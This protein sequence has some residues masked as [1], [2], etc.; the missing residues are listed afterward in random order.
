MN[1]EHSALSRI[2]GHPLQ[3]TEMQ[4][5]GLSSASAHKEKYYIT[6]EWE[7]CNYMDIRILY[8]TNIN[9]RGN[10][11]VTTLGRNRCCSGQTLSTCS[12]SYPACY[13]HAQY[14]YLSCRAIKYFPHLIN[15]LIKYIESKICV[16]IFSTTFVWNIFHS[17]KNWAGC[18]KTC[19]FVYTLSSRYSCPIVKKLEFSW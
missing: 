15:G 14:C 8:I 19:M 17:K 1:E 10:L 4:H 2:L 5:T 9:K 11:G 13:A 16:L 3:R 7:I 6:V 12:L 18:V